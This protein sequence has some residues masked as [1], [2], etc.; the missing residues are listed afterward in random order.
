MPDDKPKGYAAGIAFSELKTRPHGFAV[1]IEFSTGTP[2]PG[3]QRVIYPQGIPRTGGAG[4]HNVKLFHSFAN[5]VS[6]DSL[7]LGDSLIWNSTQIAKPAGFESLATSANTAI[8][9][10]NRYIQHGGSDYFQAGTKHDVWLW[11]RH[12]KLEGRGIH[13]QA[14]GTQWASHYLRYVTANRP[15]DLLG[16][17]MPWAVEDPR[18]LN[19]KPIEPINITDRHVV[20]GL[21]FIEPVGTE[22]TE[23]GTRII[24]ESTTLYHHGLS[25]QAFGDTQIK[26]HLSYV[27]PEGFST[28][29]DEALRFGYQY[30]WNLKQ[31]IRQDYDPNDGLNPGPFGQ[32]TAITNRNREP[33][34]YGWQSSRFG[35]QFI[36]NK[37]APIKP[38][39]VP[40]P[41][42][43]PFYKAGSVTHK[44]RPVVA[45]GINSLAMSGWGVVTNAA[46]P[47][48]PFGHDS[49]QAGRDHTIENRSRLY[50]N[51]GG[52]DTMAAGTPFIA[53]AI[54]EITFEQ[55]YSIEPPRIDL[56]VV[57]LY[58]R[59]VED[60]TAGE[61]KYGV[62][63]PALSIHWRII[64]PRW[65]FHPPAFIGEPSLHNV[66]P[67]VRQRGH[68]SEQYGDAFIRT[69]WRDVLGV[70]TSM[71]LFGRATIKDRRHWASFVGAIAPPQMLPG[72]KV[73][74]IGGLPDVQHILPPTIHSNAWLAAQ[75]PEPIAG[76][77]ELYPEGFAATKFGENQVDYY[78]ISVAYGIYDSDPF[79]KHNLTLSRR[80]VSVNE[81]HAIAPPYIES[82]ELN[83][84]VSPFT[85]YAVMDSSQ[86]AK[87]NHPQPPGRSLHYVDYSPTFNTLLK[88][89]GNH[90]ITH[91][92]QYIRPSGFAFGAGSNYGIGRPGIENRRAYIKP[93]GFRMLFVGTPITNG[94][95]NIIQFSEGD[96]SAYGLPTL[97]RP[98]YTGPQY[99]TG[100]GFN[101]A[102]FGATRIERLHREL[103]MAGF[104]SMAL[105]SSRPNDKPYTWQSL[106]V[107]EPMPTIPAGYDAQQ[108]GETT[109][110]FYVRE[111]LPDGIYSFASEY[112]PSNF[113]GRMKVYRRPDPVQIDLIA[114]V[115]LDAL[116]F[117]V[118]DLRNKAHYILPDGNSEQYRKGAPNA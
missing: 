17:G 80:Y 39:G 79:G 106:H 35:Y 52:M 114:P 111:V 55:R 9:N 90:R 40:A 61:G 53:D 22:M 58:T 34:V 73:T 42:Y 48:K 82:R 77:Q 67:E 47:L 101:S 4:E 116:T 29:P 60:A 21:R 25:M 32:W 87:E 115:G 76:A 5:P 78:G 99:V 110:S 68:N 24:P 16:M 103:D 6:W 10:R 12:I 46:D 117:G 8:I 109:I 1:G 3:E 31:I 98:P 86:Q 69:Q 95:Q 19:P 92:H 56:P 63:M 70:G 113:N 14:F 2:D 44:N 107:G 7:E 36:W 33:Q 41:A 108:H 51:V 74:R 30:I 11:E 84:R 102:S 64:T 43:E 66:T 26:N 118:P 54:R 27:Q 23:W 45:H 94:D 38:S 100:R 104:N 15:A 62:G 97:S 13:A 28:Q 49:L 83:N 57:D 72:P 81:E 50:R 37:A 93:N 71:Q 112:D 18:Y 89:V 59:Y 85:I 65:S 88:G 96:V 91:F 75:V 105:G 20:G